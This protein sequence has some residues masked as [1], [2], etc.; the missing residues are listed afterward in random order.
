MNIT[1]GCGLL[2]ATI[3]LSSTKTFQIVPFTGDDGSLVCAVRNLL[4][5]GKPGISLKNW[6]RL[7]FEDRF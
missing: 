3:V 6:G 7:F 5:K 1:I 4:P 2:C